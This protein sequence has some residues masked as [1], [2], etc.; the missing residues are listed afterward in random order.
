VARAS[1]RR[2]AVKLRLN[3]LGRR[4]LRKDG[5]LDVTIALRDGQSFE[6]FRTVLKLRR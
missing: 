6:R 5:R 4:L 3:A 1:G 2:G